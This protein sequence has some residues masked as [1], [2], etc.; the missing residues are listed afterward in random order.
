MRYTEH[1]IPEVITDAIG[2]LQKVHYLDQTLP[3]HSLSVQ[4]T[5]IYLASNS[6]IIGAV[7]H[8]VS[9]YPSSLYDPY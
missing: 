1:F 4:Q 3:S 5:H 9:I 6:K 8:V 7:E 2:I